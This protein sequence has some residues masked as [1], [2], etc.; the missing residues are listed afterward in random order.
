[1][2]KIKVKSKYTEAEIDLID[3]ETSSEINEECVAVGEDE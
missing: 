1:M 2:D 3:K